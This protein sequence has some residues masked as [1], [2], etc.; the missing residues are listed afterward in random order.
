[1]IP[2][3]FAGSEADRAV[4]AKSFWK[5]LRPMS[6]RPAINLWP[7]EHG[8]YAQL[9]VALAAALA[10][11]PAPRS[12]AQ[13]LFSVALFL[14]SEPLLG[15]LGRRGQLPPGSAARAWGRLALLGGV[16]LAAGAAAWFGLPPAR[17]QSLLPAAILGLALFALFL[18]RRE[19]TAQGEVLAAWTFAAAS[20]PIAM[21]GGARPA[22]AAQLALLLALL[23]SLGTAL[24][25]GH[26]QSLRRGGA[27]WPRACAVLFGLALLA[28]SWA[29]GRGHGLPPR[30]FL[31]LLPMAL[32]ALAVWAKPPA[33][34][35]L[36]AVGWAVAACALAGAALVVVC[37]RP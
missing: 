26:L 13:A 32:S 29:L 25:H 24:V 30:A 14:G 19:R 31:A 22:P 28:G 36:K 33:P 20:L 11:A 1:M 7:R 23:F 15:L 21:A 8:A 16:A 10:L 2:Y 35:R 37:L 6:K 17:L 5:A 4:V 9:G 27:S 34:R 12:L 3:S 18:A